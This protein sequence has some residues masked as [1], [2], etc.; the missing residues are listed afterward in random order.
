MATWSGGQR[1]IAAKLGD[2]SAMATLADADTVTSGTV[3]WGSVMSFANPGVDVALV[4]HLTGEFYCIGSGKRTLSC[5]LEIST[6]GGTNWTAGSTTAPTSEPSG[7]SG[8][9]RRTVARVHRAQALPTGSVQVRA[10]L[11]SSGGTDIAL[12]AGVLVAQLTGV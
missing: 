6:D 10:R 4:A 12:R 2:A 8:V 7:V 1:I 5:W 9:D 11:S 3:T